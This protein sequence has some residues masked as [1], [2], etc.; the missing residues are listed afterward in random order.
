MKRLLLICLLGIF[1][2][3]TYGQKANQVV[4]EIGA[5]IWVEPGMDAATIDRQFAILEEMDMP[6]TRLFLVWNWM[7]PTKGNW[8]FTL[9]DQCFESAKKHKVAIVATLMPNQAPTY[10]GPNG[11]YKV[12]DG[13]A[14]KTQQELE[15]QAYYIKSVVDHYKNHPALDTW[16]L[17]NEP[18]QFPAPDPLALTKFRTW[19]KTNY[20]N[21]I[22]ALNQSWLAG[23]ASFDSIQYNASWATGGWTW[24]GAYYDWNTFWR[25]HLTWY[26]SWIAS[27]IRKVDTKTPLH[28][29]PH[30]LFDIQER[31]DLVAWSGFLNSLMSYDK[32]NINPK[33]VAE[34]KRDFIEHPDFNP[35]IIAKA[36]KAAEGMCR[37][38]F[39]MITYD[40]VAKIVG[41]K[42]AALEEAERKL[43]HDQ[44]RETAEAPERA[45]RLL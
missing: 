23:Y 9:Y 22:K 43:A 24:P 35:E 25:D 36:S 5:Q 2:I 6:I 21:D 8:D 18:G 44:E 15:G 10:S 7:E 34:I 26:L 30:A 45:F 42:K 1:C 39:A 4:P 14:A 29:N 3:R 28:V 20:K 13:A 32:D 31:D 33:I 37:W 40:R 16:M 38:C 17:M 41:P 27:E 11:Y 12:Q 19:L